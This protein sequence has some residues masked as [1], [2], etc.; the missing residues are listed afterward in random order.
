MA[1]WFTDTHE[2]KT[3]LVDEGHGVKGLSEL[4][5]KT[6]PELFIQPPEKRFDV[7]KVLHNESIP[8]IDMSNSEDPEVI[9]MICDAAEK[10]GFFQV[11][12]HGVPVK[13]LDDVKDATKRFFSLPANE[14]K[15]YL[16]KK[17][18]TKNVR[19]VTSF[20]PEVDKVFEW[21]DYLSCFYVS[22]DEAFAFWPPVCRDQLLKYMKESEPLIK[23]LLQVLITRLNISK[24]DETNEPLLMG[25]RR[26]NLN[27]YPSCPNPEL[28]VGVGSHSDVSTLTVLLQDETGGLYVRKHDTDNWVHVL[29]I[30]G[31]LTINIGDALQIMS[32][33]RYKSIEHHVIA[34]KHENRVSVPIFVN[35]RPSDIIGP[36]PGLIERG[37]N[38]LYKHVLYSDYVKHFYR[39]SHNGKDTIDFS[40]V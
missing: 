13:V 15:S 29:P 37:E 22:D 6:L 20:I 33:G 5:I 39:K 10:W 8:I 38:A 40:K 17:S 28:T 4:N 35:P 27:Y 14:K 31:S 21:K 26:M 25:S 12:N 2:L 34:N 30:K 16:F 23:R 24:L 9:K 32:N 3:F 19:L 36:L 11:V 1:V 7:R 18:P